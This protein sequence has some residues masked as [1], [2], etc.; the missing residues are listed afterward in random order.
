[1]SP[2]ISLPTEFNL[3]MPEMATPDMTFSPTFSPAFSPVFSPT[4]P[5]LNPTFNVKVE[6]APCHYQIN[7]PDQPPPVLNVTNI[8]PWKPIAILSFANTL[9]FASLSYAIHWLFYIRQ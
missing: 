9:V 8:L 3:K 7:V 2:Q 6:P 4:L 1:M 5:E